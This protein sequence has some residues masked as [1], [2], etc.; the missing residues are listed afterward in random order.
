MRG[1]CWLLALKGARF[2]T[3]T[4]TLERLRSIKTPRAGE[5]QGASELITDSCS[6]P[7]RLHERDPPKGEIIERLRRE[8]T[9]R[10]L[11]F[12]YCLLTLG[13]SHNRAP[14]QGMGEG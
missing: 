7:S 14:R 1:I 2:V 6:P 9:N 11:H 4:H 8:E 12:E 5:A 10:R 3:R 13:A